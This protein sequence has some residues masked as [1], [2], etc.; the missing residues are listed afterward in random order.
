[1]TTILFVS[2][3]FEYRLLKSSM[4][5]GVPLPDRNTIVCY[6]Y[7]KS[8]SIPGERFGYVLVPDEMEDS[9]RV[10]LAVC[11]AGRSYGYICAPSLLQRTIARVTGQVADI[12]EYRKNRDLLY[13]GLTEIGFECV[14]PQGAFY[15]FVKTIGDEAQFCE[16][17]K[18]LDILVVA[19]SGFGCPGYIRL[20]YCVSNDMIRRSMPAFKKLYDS[21]R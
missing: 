21:Y 11:G 4:G 19:G 17:A 10:Y 9:Q 13:N 5:D 3:S 14:P 12:S 1:M 8:L 15:L 7:S 18:A 6:S 16:R 2:L 20:A